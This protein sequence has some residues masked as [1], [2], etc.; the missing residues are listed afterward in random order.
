MKICEHCHAVQEDDAVVCSACGASMSQEAAPAAEPSPKKNKHGLIIGIAAVVVIAAVGVGLFFGLRKPEELPSE[1][2]PAMDAETIDGEDAASAGNRLTATDIHHI[3]AYGYPSYSIHYETDENGEAVYSYLDKDG[4]AVTMDPAELDAWMDEIV[5][6]CGDQKLTN[7]ELQYYYNDQIYT[8]YNMYG[9]YLSFFMDTSKGF[10]EQLAMDQSSTW[11]QS[12]LDASVEMFRQVSALYQDAQAKGFTPSE[13][14]QAYI[15]QVTDLETMAAQYGYTDV[16]QF[17]ADYAGPGATVDSYRAYMQATLLANLYA[18]HLAEALEVTDQDVED[19]YDANTSTIQSNYGITKVD[20]NV[21]NV[22]HILIQPEQST[23]ED[24]S[25][26]ITDEAWAAAEAEA[27]RIYQLWQDGEATEDSFAALAGEYSTDG[28]SSANGGLYE[29]VYPGQ[30]V[31]EFNDWCFADGRQAGD[32]GIVKTSYGYHI[33][34]FSGEGD[35]IYWRMAA[36]DL[37]RSEIAAKDRQELANSYANV[38]D[39]SKAILLDAVAPSAPAT[40]A[41]S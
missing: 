30:M 31:T 29:D 4:Q 16:E 37:C 22:R 12:F 40:E 36:E 1:E 19:Y 10:D 23:A 17:V 9:S 28:G 32:H 5:A 11:Q 7:R 6:V 33:M 38:I 8:F 39:L 35:Y 13:E 34:F 14:D 26:T 21:I 24:G 25:A 18:S 3:N 20:K 2:A 41:E 15:D 27:Q